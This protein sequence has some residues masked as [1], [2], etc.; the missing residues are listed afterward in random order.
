MSN[1]YII[2]RNKHREKEVTWWVCNLIRIRRRSVNTQAE[3]SATIYRLTC[4]VHMGAYMEQ[5][6]NLS[7]LE[8]PNWMRGTNSWICNVASA[9]VTC[10]TRL[11]I[12]TSRLYFLS[13]HSGM[14]TRSQRLSLPP[15]TDGPL[16]CPPTTW[17]VSVSTHSSDSHSGSTCKSGRLARLVACLLVGQRV[18]LHQ[19]LPATL[20]QASSL[21]CA[22]LWRHEVEVSV[23]CG[24]ALT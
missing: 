9:W 2:Q 22:T 3:R 15:P 13:T 11:G 14:V 19:S 12:R 24:A 6:K 8:Q 20:L 4:T 7:S 5:R 16:Y 1:T 21:A 18:S 17:H 23:L 10:P